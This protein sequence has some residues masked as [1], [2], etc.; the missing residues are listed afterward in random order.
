[1]SELEESEDKPYSSGSSTPPGRLTLG[2]YQEVLAKRAEIESNGYVSQLEDWLL[3]DKWP[4]LDACYILAGLVPKTLKSDEEQLVRVLDG[5]RPSR[6]DI[7]EYE[8][9]K[10]L[11]L[12]SDHDKLNEKNFAEVGEASLSSTVRPKYAYE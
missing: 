4:E 8:R 3:C 10:S 5:N 6:S 12:R 2:Q 1:M 11:W 7:D 9:I